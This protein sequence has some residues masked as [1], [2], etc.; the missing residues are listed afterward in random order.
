MKLIEVKN[1]RL[2]YDGVT[3]RDNINVSVPRGESFC[4]VGDNG[5]GKSTLMRAILSL[6]PVS[7]GEIIMNGIKSSEIGYLP[8]RMNSRRDFPASI[9]EVVISGCG[10]STLFYRSEHKKKAAAAIERVGLTGMEKRCFSE[11]SG[12]QAQRVL[13]ARALCAAKSLILLD[14]PVAG[15]DPEATADMY[16]CI[17]SLNRDGMTVIMISHDIASVLKYATNILHV[18]NNTSFACGK[19]EYLKFIEGNEKEGAKDEYN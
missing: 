7:G 9:Y 11:L 10:G 18:G 16:N 17:E 4:I 3:I 6:K 14:E 1:V 2:A 19:E 13:L 8:Q 5:S 12:G 15:L